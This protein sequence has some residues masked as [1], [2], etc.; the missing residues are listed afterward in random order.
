[1]GHR[2]TATLKDGVQLTG[3]LHAIDPASGSVSLLVIENTKQKLDKINILGV[4]LESLVV[5]NVVFP[6]KTRLPRA[7]RA[8]EQWTA[9][10]EF[11]EVEI[12]DSKP[13]VWD[14]F[15][16]NESKF[17][18]T[19]DWD[20]NKYTVKIDRSVED[21]AAKEAEAARIAREIENVHNR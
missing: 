12:E 1:M 2:V 21:F 8:L 16:A 14:Q 17:G 18:V 15:A 4:S 11:K 9:D 7:N 10:P 19:T 3:V 13:G 5:L 20:E 6:K